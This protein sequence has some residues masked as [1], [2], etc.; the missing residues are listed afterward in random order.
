MRI[1]SKGE[2]GLRAIFDLAQ[3]FGKGPVQSED[4][5]GRQGIPVNY[6][7]QL[8]ILMR[9]AGLIESL[10]GPQGGH[11]LARKPEDITLLE[12]LTV[13]EGPLLPTENSREDL[14]PLQPEDYAL[15]TAVWANLRASLEQQLSAI[16]LDDLCQRKRERSGDVMYY[17]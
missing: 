10:R 14:H 8:L 3:R 4:I 5:A 11:M 16:T 12:V 2:Y 15:I 9:R 7:N 6:L 1:S 17:I 13:L